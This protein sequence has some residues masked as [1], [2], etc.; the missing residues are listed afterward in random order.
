MRAVCCRARRTAGAWWAIGLYHAG[1]ASPCSSAVAAART[2]LRR[3]AP[4]VRER[5]VRCVRGRRCDDAAGSKLGSCAVG[6]RA[7]GDMC[8][9]RITRRHRGW[10]S[11]WERTLLAPAVSASVAGRTARGLA[12]VGFVVTTRA[13]HPSFG[14]GS[15]RRGV[16]RI[17][18]G[19]VWLVARAHG[20]QMVGGREPC[21]RE[22]RARSQPLPC[23]GAEVK[24]R[25]APSQAPA[26]S[27]RGDRSIALV[28][29]LDRR[30]RGRSSRKSGGDRARL[31]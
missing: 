13:C 30:P 16:S 15:G 10:R 1:C 8:G 7:A 20:W 9:W 4:A 25:R 23:V 12:S 18:A 19:V 26:V 22:S 21:R 3:L 2:A 17:V 29:A 6:T 31:T 14:L 11:A 24:A 28:H 27:F 5:G